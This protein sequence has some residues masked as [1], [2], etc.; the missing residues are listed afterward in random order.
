VEGVHVRD[1]EEEVYA[2]PAPAH[3]G[4]LAHERQAQRARAQRRHRRIGLRVVR[5]QIEAERVAV[6]LDRIVQ[7]VHFEEDEIEAGDAHKFRPK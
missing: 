6:E 7:A 1:A 4:R 5:D 2:A 3:R